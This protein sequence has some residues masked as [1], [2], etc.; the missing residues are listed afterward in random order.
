MPAS[1]T[2][3]I[4]DLRGVVRDL[5]WSGT[6][7]SIGSDAS[8]D[9]TLR[10]RGIADRHCILQFTD[11]GVLLRDHG[12]RVETFINNERLDDPRVVGPGD[13]IYLGEYQLELLALTPAVAPPPRRASPP[14][15]SFARTHAT[16]LAL[17]GAAVVLIAAAVFWSPTSTPTI[18]VAPTT[19]PAAAPSLPA[20][21]LT[22]PPPPRTRV[23]IRHEVIPGEL[24]PDIATRYG[25]SIRELVDD[26]GLNPDLP[27]PSGLVLTIHA[28]DPPLPKL[29]LR[30][31]VEPGDTW[32]GL[33]ER[34]ELGVELL[35][36][37]N[38]KLRGELVPGTEFIVWVDPQIERRRDVS[39]PWRY[40]VTPGALSVG[41]PSAGTLEQGIQLPPIPS[42]YE[43][44]FPQFQYGSSQ[45]IRELQTAIASFRQRYRYQGV[46]VVSNLSQP[47]GG[48][49][50]P[51]TSHQ[52]GR[53]VDIW[54]PALKG[55]YQPRHL[56]TDQKPRDAEINWFAAWGLVESL[57]A[58]DQIV[59]IFLDQTRLPKLYEAGVQMGASP[60]LL[61]QI[62]WQPNSAA[63][64]NAP[65]RHAAAHTG[66]IHVR[67]KCG[68][69]ETSCKGRLEIE[70][71]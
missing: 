38:P 17:G 50:P 8:C 65:V 15:A 44:I 31:T 21:P 18:S 61:A 71:P 45:T 12:S 19:M 47:G 41:V 7:L 46:L 34:F 6:S 49:F 70:E 68:P 35:H 63:R 22:T 16:P 28:H 32:A 66:H 5:T 27:P 1:I 23:T 59:Y 4:Y 62:Q 56:V 3:R 13:R 10:G 48:P 42:L 26:N 30:H 53:D 39:V 43:R 40:A 58:T 2:L 25:V 14:A 36:R 64:A 20:P 60:E 55:T 57:L 9:L 37:Y 24:I 33:S 52:S 51:H 67:F 69:D 11:G 54:L 29:R